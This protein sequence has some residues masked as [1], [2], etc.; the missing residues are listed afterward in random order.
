M[1]KLLSITTLV[2]GALCWCA[3]MSPITA[4]ELLAQKSKLKPSPS[5]DIAPKKTEQQEPKTKLESGEKIPVAPPPPP[6][7]WKPDWKK[8]KESKQESE[9][10]LTKEKGTGASEHKAVKKTRKKA[11]K[12][13][14][15]KSIDRLEVTLNTHD[16]TQL[17][18]LIKHASDLSGKLGESVIG[19]L[20]NIT[21]D[22]KLMTELM[23][24]LEKL[25]IKSPQI[26][27]PLTKIIETCASEEYLKKTVELLKLLEC[28]K[29]NA[30][31]R[32]GDK[33]CK[34][35][36]SD[37]PVKT[38]GAPMGAYLK[39][40]LQLGD[41]LLQPFVEFGI[42]GF[43]LQDTTGKKTKYDGMVMVA[44]D[45]TPKIADDVKMLAELFSTLTKILK[46][47]S[48]GIKE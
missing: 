42:D 33:V 11:G 37:H 15:K 40:I 30:A 35:I 14:K 44:A 16:A 41:E 32:Q 10:T 47:I 45:L 43:I 13:T 18:T 6:A 39:R 29:K 26:I 24:Y 4:E 20:K 8:E 7:D 22:S 5:K 19:T 34:K 31:A 1:R 36:E 46:T 25:A 9:K 28:L 27:V 17:Q 23:D 2:C 48:E 3:P 38:G 12:K 21:K